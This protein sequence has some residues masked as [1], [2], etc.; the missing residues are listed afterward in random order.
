MKNV[1]LI[2][3][4]GNRIVAG[5]QIT[6]EEARS[7]ADINDEDLPFL[8]AMADAIRQKYVGKDVDLC[9]IVNGRSGMCSEDCAFCAQSAHHHTQVNVYPLMTE[10]ELLSAAK[11]AEDGGALRFAIVTSGR[12]MGDEGEFTKILRALKRIKQETKLHVCCSLGLL[13]FENAKA[14][15][16]A[17]VS[18]YHHNIETSESHYSSICN[19]HTYKDRVQ[20]IKVVKEAGLEVCSGG[21]LGMGESM[22]QRLEMAFALKAMNVDSVPLNILHRMKGTPLENL[23]PITPLEVL[24]S[25]ALFRFILPDRGLRT[26]GGREEN[27]RDL[28][29]LSLRSGINGMMIGGYLTTHGRDYSTD[30]RMIYDLELSPL[31]A[32]QAVHAVL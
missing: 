5:G 15:K 27:L 28:Q 13:S 3:E 8:L 21:I 18:R 32:K 12:G 11:Q 2:M 1:Q 14:L 31:S 10:E 24:K 9:S 30:L 4:L 20:T 16:A 26:A 23:Q 29:A 22:S 7:L 17:G 6:M 25:F 19:T